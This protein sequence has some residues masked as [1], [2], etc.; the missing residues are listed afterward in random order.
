MREPAVAGMFYRRG[1]DILRE[2]VHD[3]FT[4][5]LGPGKIPALASP[6]ARRIRGAVFPHA[7]YEYSGQVAAYSYA[8]LK[9]RNSARVVVISPCHVDNF[10]YSS[11]R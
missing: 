7:G 9:G 6:G 5:R 10:P 2:Q 8:L 1:K 3:C 4:H 11:T